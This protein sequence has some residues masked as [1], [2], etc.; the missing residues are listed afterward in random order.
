MADKNII[1][2][3]KPLFSFSLIFFYFAAFVLAIFA[4]N[5]FSTLKSD[6]KLFGHLDPVWLLMVLIFQAGT[7]YFNALI[8][9]VLLRIYT[10]KAIFS[11]KNILK[12]SIVMLFLNQIVPSAGL[13]GNAFFSNLIV[14]KG[15]T[16][17]KSLSLMSLVL[18]TS[19]IS[20]TL[21]IA[22]L[23]IVG[24]FFNFP[25]FFFAILMVGVLVFG[26]ISTFTALAGRG[27][28]IHYVLNKISRIGFIK[29]NVQR[30]KAI[31]KS[32]LNDDDNP[33]KIL[34][35]KGDITLKSMAYKIGIVV[36]DVL[37][38]Y[39][40]FK[41]FGISVNPIAVSM[42]YIL[43]QIIQLLP[44]SPGG[45]LVYE[46][47]MTFFF[48]QMGVPLEAAV[49]VVLLFRFLSFWLPIPVG[50][51]LYKDLQQDTQKRAK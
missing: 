32:E 3:K 1:S 41:G 34:L 44:L 8:Y 6:L 43:T 17:E 19:F 36:F 20:T 31:V 4:I 46:G 48:T 28:T 40:L 15:I 11:L 9:Q 38:I 37:T 25:R 45:I 51:F 47:S 35:S 49:T 42:G 39:A 16:V 23:I 12:V 30:Y 2:K 18:L 13:S 24:L 26:V 10:K 22:L 27:K 50:L 21:I 7:Y 14:K 33:I 5:Y 29:Q